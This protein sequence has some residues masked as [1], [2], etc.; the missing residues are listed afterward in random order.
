VQT[1]FL[2]D[3]ARPV[4]IEA[5]SIYGVISLVFWAITIIVSVKYVAL[6]MR[7]DNDGEGGIMALIALLLRLRAGK[8]RRRAFMALAA[9]GIV[10]ASLFFGD[11]VI[12]PAI[13]VLSAVE[14]LEV[15]APSLHELVVPIAAAIL[16]AL[17]A[18]QRLGTSVVGRLF[19]PV[20]LLWFATIAVAG[21]NEITQHPA[22]L[23][24][25]SPTYGVRF[26]ADDSLTA[27]LAL[28][29]VVLAVTGAEALYADMGHFGRAPIRR[30]WFLAVFPA[31]TLNYLGQGALLIDEP[32]AASNPF[33]LLMP[34]WARLPMVF[35]ATLAT[36][37]AS[38]AVISGA[39]SVTR[40][41][42][43]LG[44]LPRLRIRHTSEHE[45]QVYSPFI[46]WTLM[47]AVLIVVFAFESSTKLASAYGIAVTGTITITGLLFSV[48]ARVRWHWPLW[49]VIALTAAFG[50][51]DL[52]F[53]GANLTKIASGG[54]LPLL[55][56]AAVSTVLFTWQKGRTIVTRNRERME[57]SLRAFVGQLHAQDPPVARVRGTAVFLNR[58]SKTTP[59][60]MRA[61]VEH[62][63]TLHEHVV[64]LSIE[65]EPVPYV[66]EDRRLTIS[67]L[68]FSDDGISH[69][70]ARFGFQEMPN[71]PEVLRLAAEHGLE[72]PLEIPEASY[73]L[74]K[75]ELVATDA[76]GLSRW[77]KRLFLATAELAADPVDYFV[78]PR[79]RTVILGAQCPV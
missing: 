33:Y 24:A 67:D 69:V 52:S 63:H 72:C 58:G 14:G 41:A 78:L 5:D 7:A 18:V 17:F 16:V 20:M 30:A 26:F 32:R 45:G 59:L 70:T 11:S 37:I 64:V 27:F 25:L 73:F 6:I 55:V 9:L 35:L 76:P 46:N 68:G 77:R 21:V 39:Y 36:I 48:V 29:G 22:I 43:R 23:R 75:L 44:Y 12:T 66:N 57:G 51:I 49:L 34:H 13:S 61:N 54:W 56:A 4:P 19:G 40:Q 71:V 74:S 60:A 8:A 50:M 10:G 65:T 79:E 47:I 62:N 31:L 42:V 2:R 38:Q 53:L 3:A 1:V 28:G 15:A